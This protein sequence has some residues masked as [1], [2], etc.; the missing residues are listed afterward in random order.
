MSNVIRAVLSEKPHV[1]KAPER[2]LFVTAGQG[3]GTDTTDE[4]QRAQ[5]LHIKELMESIAQREQRADQLLKDA[6]IQAEIMKTE[7]QSEKDRIIAE[8]QEAA[9]AAR[10]DAIKEGHDEGYAQGMKEGQEAGEQK[11]RDEMAETIRQGNAKAEKTLSDAEAAKRDYVEQAEQDIVHICMAVIEKVL[12]QHFIDVPQVMLPVVREAILKVKDQQRIIVHVAPDY[13]DMI[14]MARDE[15]RGL[16]EGSTST[17]EVKS[18]DSLHPGDCVI[19]TPNG[20]VDARLATQLELIK[21]AV[22]KV[23]I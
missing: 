19:E 21:Q 17:L 3:E 4:G 15:L 2:K 1:I 7:A 10:E 16:L 22:E 12:P 6:R 23:M 20:S 11:V 18:D 9:A 13:Y 5:D 14:L 8:G